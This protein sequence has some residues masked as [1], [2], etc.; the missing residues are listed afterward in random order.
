[1]ET[2]DLSEQIN[3]TVRSLL[4]SQAGSI[5]PIES[6]L[7]KI[8]E[9]KLLEI[10]EGQAGLGMANG[11][12]ATHS[13]STLADTQAEQQSSQ[14]GRFSPSEPQSRHVAASTEGHPL[15]TE[16]VTRSKTTDFQRYSYWF[17]T[18]V[19]ITTS[20]TRNTQTINSLDPRLAQRITETEICFMPANFLM[21]S[22][23]SAKYTRIAAQY[24]KPSMLMH[25]EPLRIISPQSP[26]AIA[27]G[28]GDLLKVQK[29]LGQGHAAFSDRFSDGTTLVDACLTSMFGL[30]ELQ[31]CGGNNFFTSF[32]QEVLRK[33]SRLVHLTAWL[34]Q[35]GVDAG[36]ARTDE[37]WQ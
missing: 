15:S 25:L 30:L 27:V 31:S 36:A 34:L 19:L 35:Q 13:K 33:W 32:S 12:A 4:G 3:D 2:K 37:Q 21:A 22:A 9:E 29:L 26:M 18:V 1:M 20:H 23:M 6:A 7:R 5:K 11:G 24:R 14:A 10:N 17:G 16:T 28:C 8:L